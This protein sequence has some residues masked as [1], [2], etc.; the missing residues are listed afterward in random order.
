MPNLLK[1]KFTK[2]RVN[3]TWRRIHLMPNS[4]GAELTRIL[5]G[6]FS[7]VFLIFNAKKNTK[8]HVGDSYQYLFSNTI[9]KNSVF[10]FHQLT[11]CA[12]IM[13]IKF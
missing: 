4:P 13:F 10:T 7:S 9:S 11:V 3:Y 12:F 8:I 5:A 6:F 1:A 2:G